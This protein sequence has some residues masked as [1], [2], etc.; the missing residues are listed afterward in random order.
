MT[1]KK[2]LSDFIGKK[3]SYDAICDMGIRV[4]E[5]HDIFA[6]DYIPPLSTQNKIRSRIWKDFPLLDIEDTWK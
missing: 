3:C 2:A 5:L 1:I 6:A 4:K